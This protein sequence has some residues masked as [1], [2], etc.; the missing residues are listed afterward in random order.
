MGR[1]LAALYDVG[2][3]RHG[4]LPLRRRDHVLHNDRHLP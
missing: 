1:A 3:A 4:S 2:E